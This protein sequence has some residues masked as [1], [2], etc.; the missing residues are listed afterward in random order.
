LP[1]SVFVEAR[2]LQGRLLAGDDGEIFGKGHDFGYFVTSFSC[3]PSNA[4][5]CL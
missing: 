5:S 1:G 4:A 3:A 2:E